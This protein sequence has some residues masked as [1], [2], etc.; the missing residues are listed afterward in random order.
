VED[1]RK[2]KERIIPTTGADKESASKLLCK[3]C[4]S[5]IG[6]CSDLQ[7]REEQH[8]LMQSIESLKKLMTEEFKQLNDRMDAYEEKI[9]SFIH[10]DK[11]YLSFSILNFIYHPYSL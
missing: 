11:S 1:I 9:V 2:P 5:E 7:K 8:I 10:T 6:E 3:G 4:R